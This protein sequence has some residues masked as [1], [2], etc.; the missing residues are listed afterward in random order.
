[1]AVWTRALPGP[2]ARGLVYEVGVDG[3]G[4]HIHAGSRSIEMWRAA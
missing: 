3:R 2:D 4:I 1:M